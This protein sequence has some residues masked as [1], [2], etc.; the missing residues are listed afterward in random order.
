MA[1]PKFAGLSIVSFGLAAHRA[2]VDLQSADAQRR[3]RELGELSEGHEVN[4]DDSG[5]SSADEL[6][7]PNRFRTGE[8]VKTGRGLFGGGGRKFVPTGSTLGD[9]QRRRAEAQS[10]A[11][12]AK[13]MQA[14]VSQRGQFIGGGTRRRTGSLLT[15]PRGLGESTTSKRRVLGG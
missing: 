10:V 8:T 2:G 11:D 15:S 12:R 13:R 9:T 1:L 3:L 14:V 7:N 6:F 5:V 4:F